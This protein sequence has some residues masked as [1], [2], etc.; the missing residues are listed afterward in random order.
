MSE[1]LNLQGA[2]TV[3]HLDL[4]TTLRVAEQ[5]VGRVDRM[6]SPYD[7]I[8]AWWPHEGG[9]FAIRSD[10]LLHA[11]AE[12]SASL[13]GANLPIPTKGGGQEISVADHAEHL[14]TQRAVA[15]DGIQDALAPVRDFITGSRALVP[16]GVFATY[17]KLE[18]RV[19][20]HVSPV[21]SQSPWAFIAVSS[22]LGGAPR[23]MLLEGREPQITVRLDAVA[24][25]LRHH[26]MDD[27]PPRTHDAAS[28]DWLDRFLSAA[29]R[30]END[31]LPRRMQRALDQMNRVTLAWSEDA[32]RQGA[33]DVAER[34]GRLRALANPGPDDERADPHEVAERWLQ[35]V[36]PLLDDVRRTRHARYT[37][38]RD[39]DKRLVSDPLELHA[40]ETAFSGASVMEPFA[41]R[42]SACIIGVPDGPAL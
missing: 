26:L 8:E 12:E 2:S 35:L 41:H 9:A 32:F 19:I 13:L 31:L 30:S 5:R 38:L 40:V 4:P 28:Q 37:R 7:R 39:I 11:R 21:T 18:N 1:G 16:P 14:E 24:E 42:I 20:A 29:E 6:D 33:Y 27:P 25:R 36:R 22:R 15:W 23:W 3:V 34:W 10:E 17:A